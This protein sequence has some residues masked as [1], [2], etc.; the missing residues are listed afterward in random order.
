MMRHGS[1]TK[2]L[3]TAAERI[4]TTPIV[5]SLF[6]AEDRRGAGAKSLNVIR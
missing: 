4:P 2:K 5:A 1:E 6:L 3:S